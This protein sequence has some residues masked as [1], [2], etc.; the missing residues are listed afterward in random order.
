MKF[1]LVDNTLDT[2]GKQLHTGMPVRLCTIQSE[3]A[4]LLL[5]KDEYLSR[6]WYSLSRSIMHSVVQEIDL[7]GGGDQLFEY[8]VLY[9]QLEQRH[10]KH[11][12][13][14]QAGRAFAGLISQI[15]LDAEIV[16][17]P[18]SLTKAV[19]TEL[20]ITYTHQAKDRARTNRSFRVKVSIE[21]E[22]IR[23]LSTL[24]KNQLKSR[25]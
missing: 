19:Y 20:L 6:Y 21:P 2:L 25:K 24:Y 16:D 15:L 10:P 17:H 14:R 18:P 9:H 22:V 5:S 3:A 11:L 8:E 13:A 1:T 7:R 4:N 12:Q 23:M